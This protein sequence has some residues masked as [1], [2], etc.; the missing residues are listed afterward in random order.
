MKAPSSE[1]VQDFVRTRLTTL[2]GMPSWPLE[3]A[4]VIVLGHYGGLFST[5]VPLSRDWLAII[6]QIMPDD[7]W[8]KAARVLAALLFVSCMVA[9]LWDS[10]FYRVRLWLALA[11]LMVWSVLVYSCWRADVP[12]LIWRL[13]AAFWATQLWVWILLYVQRR[14]EREQL[15]KGGPA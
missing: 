5:Y 7:S 10:P 6:S 12:F 8:G 9:W 14:G 4:G 3:L 1:R 15:M 13:Y 11:G 2:F